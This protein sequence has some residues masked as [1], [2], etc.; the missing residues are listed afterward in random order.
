MLA[1]CAAAATAGVASHVFYFNRGEHHLHSMMYTQA[2]FAA[3]IAAVVSLVNLQDYGLY[4]AIG[5]TTTVALGYLV[6]VWTSLIIYRVFLCPWTKFPGPWQASI[7]A[8]WL[9]G[10]LTQQTAPQKF[11]ALHKK[12]GKYV[13]IG[14]DTLSISDAD[15][16]G[17]AFGHNT[18]FRKSIWYD[19]NKPFDSLHMTRD[20]A[21]HDRRR[22]MWAPAFSDKA[23]REY[24]P[25]VRSH[26][27]ELLEQIRKREGQPMEMGTWFNLYSFDVMGHLAFGKD[28]G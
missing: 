7:S 3:C 18:K 5:T 27:Y 9:F 24:E 10:H 6:G 2:F 11:Q 4:A 8:F 13:R 16:H 21:F 28:Y 19:L 12:Y 15:V 26:N 23:L 22:R 20:K 25:K 1:T 14:P 17:A